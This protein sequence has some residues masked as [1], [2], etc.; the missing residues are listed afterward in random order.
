LAFFEILSLLD[1]AVG[2]LQQNDRHISYHIITV[3]LY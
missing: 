2:N 1:T 3:S